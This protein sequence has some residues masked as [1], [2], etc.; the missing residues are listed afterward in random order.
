MTIPDKIKIGG[1]TF[2]VKKDVERLGMGPDYSANIL[3]DKAT[4]EMCCGQDEQVNQ[5]DFL[6]EIIHG[7][8]WNLGDMEN[9]NDEVLVDKLAGAFYQLIVDNPEVFK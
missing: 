3:F 4:I 6:H 1:V 5:R 7:I 8:F 9:K 2:T